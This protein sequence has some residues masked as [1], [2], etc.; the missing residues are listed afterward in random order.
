[1]AIGRR[2]SRDQD[3]ANALELDTLTDGIVG[4]NE[5]GWRRG[6]SAGTR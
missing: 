4:H 3:N 1:M 6:A 5:G 2:R